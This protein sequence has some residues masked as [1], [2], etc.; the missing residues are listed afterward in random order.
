MPQCASK[1]ACLLYG[2]VGLKYPAVILP[3]CSVWSFVE[4]RVRNVGVREQ[5]AEEDV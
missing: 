5:G 1:S 2:N 4:G 3:L